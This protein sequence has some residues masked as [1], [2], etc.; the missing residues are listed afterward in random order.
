MTSP[1]N[2][3]DGLEES[4]MDFHC[5]KP[6]QWAIKEYICFNSDTPLPADSHEW[7]IDP[8]SLHETSVSVV[9]I[10]E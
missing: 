1:P 3:A 9:R 7:D 6:M 10:F 2:G 8:S 5:M 4:S